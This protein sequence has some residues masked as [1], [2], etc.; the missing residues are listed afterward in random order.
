MGRTADSEPLT[1]RAVEG[2][3]RTAGSNHL[4]TALFES[5]LSELLNVR[6]SYLEAKEFAQKAL[7]IQEKELGLSAHNT[8][9]ARP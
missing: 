2:L 1:R 7:S 3:A 8:L 6:G 5:N 4:D 9:L